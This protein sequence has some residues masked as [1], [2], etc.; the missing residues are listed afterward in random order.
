MTETWVYD[1]AVG[2][3]DNKDLLGGKGANLANM[4]QLGLPV[5]PGFTITTRACN[6]YSASGAFP[7]GL[8]EQVASAIQRL[9]DKSA[10]RF[11]T[12]DSPLL[13]SVRSGAKFSMPGMMDTILNL[14]MNDETMAAME[15]RSG[16]PRF[17]RDSYRR[18]IQ[19]FADV[20]MGIELHHFEEEFV[21]VRGEREDFEVTAEE[22]EKLIASYKAIY[23]QHAGAQF[24]QDAF[25]QLRLAVEAVFKSWNNPRAQTYR[26][27][28]NIPDDLGTACNVQSMVFGNMGMTSGTGVCFSRNPATGAKGVFGEFLINAQGEDVVAGIRTPEDISKLSAEMPEVSRQLFELIEHLERHFRDMQDIEFTVEE[29]TLYILQTR[30]GKRTGPAAV[31]IAVDM[32]E[33]GLVDK[34]KALLMVEPQHVDQLLHPQIDPS[35]ILHIHPVDTGGLPASPGAAVGK[36]VLSSTKAVEL[37]AAAKAEGRTEKLLLVTDETTPDDID[38]MIA[39]EGILTARGGMTSHA[40]VVARGM[41]KPCVASAP[42]LSFNKDGTLRL[43]GQ[44]FAEGDWLTID[45]GRGYTYPGALKLSKPTFTGKIETLLQWADQTRR[46]KVRTNADN[47]HDSAQAVEFGA[48][49]IGLTRT[50][51]MFFEPERLPHVRAMILSETEEERREHLSKIYGFQK[52]DF[53]GIFKVMTGKPVTIR[54]LDPPLHEFLP[55]DEEEINQMISEVIGEVDAARRAQIHARIHA[56][57]ESNPMLGFRGCRLGIVYPEINEMQVKA[58]IAAA[59]EAQQGGSM[60]FPEIMVPLIGSVAELKKVEPLLRRVAEQTMEEYGTH[61]PYAF[62]TMIE[63][64]RAAVTADEIAEVAEFFSFGT[65][66]LTQMGMGV[67]RDDAQRFLG[68]Y[69]ELGIYDEDPFNSLDQAGIGKLVEMACRLGREGRPGI[70]LGICGEHGGDPRSI[71]FFHRTGLD[72]VSCSPFRVPIARLAAAQA[73]LKN[74]STQEALVGKA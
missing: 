53:L 49:G 15:Q 13:V 61:I 4:T 10:K 32:V 58:I 30:G 21:R 12:S 69:V 63:V 3:K 64:P 67:S 52:G 68:K 43:G 25:E 59:I 1:F 55:H 44:V 7:E 46:L 17:A 47:P 36:I 34:E 45:G 60:V 23:K 41:G 37:V 48:E 70:K 50:E 29:G 33:E 57:H 14:G 18:L 8:W 26:R 35:E 38:G 51:H 54:L 22:L 42:T 73:E 16:N 56:M 27:E 19:T 66:D 65:N 40:A 28:S 6:A 5:P 31:N 9:E 71:E 74:R 39:C 2:D 20:A 62:G 24:P 72:Y 11:G